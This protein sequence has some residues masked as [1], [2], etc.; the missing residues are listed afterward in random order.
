MLEHR[1]ATDAI[2]SSVS[3]EIESTHLQNAEKVS[4]FVILRLATCGSSP[5]RSD[6]T[7]THISSLLVLVH[8]SR[9][10]GYRHREIP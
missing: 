8:S 3:F 4:K 6:D 2:C 7:Q 10:Q 1:L 5:T 9:I